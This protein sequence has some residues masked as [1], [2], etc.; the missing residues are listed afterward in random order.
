MELL[1]KAGCEDEQQIKKGFKWLL[2]VRQDDGGWAA[3]IRIHNAKWSEVVDGED[4]LQPIKR[5]PFSHMI[6]GV[7]LRAFT[8]HA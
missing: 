2:S 1:V 3:P 5:K 6:T 4:A 8:A 7:V